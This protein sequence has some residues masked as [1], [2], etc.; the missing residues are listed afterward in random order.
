MK[1]PF[2]ERSPFQ[3]GSLEAIIPLN[4]QYSVG[5]PIDEGRANLSVLC[6]ISGNFPRLSQPLR[7]N[8]LRDFN[9]RFVGII[10]RFLHAWRLLYSSFSR[11]PIDW[12]TST[13]FLH[14]SS[15]NSFMFGAITNKLG[16]LVLFLQF[17]KFM[18]F[19]IVKWHLCEGWKKNQYKYNLKKI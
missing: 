2:Y 6:P 18:Y 4:I 5:F 10:L 13:K 19:K 11:S 14:P 9:L 12:W 1:T 17:M 8:N 7:K 15:S 3:M 16:N